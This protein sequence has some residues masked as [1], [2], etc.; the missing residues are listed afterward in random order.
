MKTTN[1]L[2]CLALAFAGFAALAARA[3]D[4]VRT[5]VITANDQMKFSV[6]QIEAAP[7]EKLH[8]QLHNEGT[9][10]KEAMGH[11]WLLLKAGTDVNAFALAAIAAHDTGYV[12]K[13]LAGQVLAAVPLLGPKEVGDVIFTCPAQ[14][15]KY[16][17]ICSFTGHALAGMRGELIVK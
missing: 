15:G 12:P 4:T 7:G 11:N 3:E 1:I 14:P 17:F 16:P 2:S 6:T 13:A 9:L 10:P 8:V 5:I